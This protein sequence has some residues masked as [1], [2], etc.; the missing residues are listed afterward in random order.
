MRQTHSHYQGQLLPFFCSRSVYVTALVASGLFSETI[1]PS[2][3]QCRKVFVVVVV[4]FVA[5]KP[6]LHMPY[7]ASHLARLLC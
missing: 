5:D 6:K 3:R 2:T 4:V 7:L 1:E